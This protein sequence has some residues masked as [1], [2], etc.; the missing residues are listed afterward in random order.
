MVNITADYTPRE[1]DTA[2]HPKSRTDDDE[3]DPPANDGD[4]TLRRFFRDPFGG[5][6]VTPRMFRRE[7][8]GTGFIVDRNGYIITNNHV[9][10]KMD[11]IRV[12]LHGDTTEYRAHL[13]GTDLETDLA[14]IKID[15]KSP[16]DAGH[17]RQFRCGAGGR[18]GGG[19][20]FAVRAGSI[21]DGG[22]RQR[23][24]A[25]HRRGADVPALHPNRRGHQSGQ[26]RRSAAEH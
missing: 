12:R 5:H 22:H 13:I 14:V 9:I 10:D 26:Q 11:H 19:H 2:V 18:L 1:S 25:R 15:P 23:D 24:G 3:E 21:R 6:G 16:A 8:S 20:R 17:H 7:Q 4:D